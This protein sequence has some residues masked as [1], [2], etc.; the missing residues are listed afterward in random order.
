MGGLEELA[1]FSLTRP[2]TLRQPSVCVKTDCRRC[3]ANV[4]LA[5]FTGYQYGGRPLGLTYVKYMNAGSG[6]AMEDAE[7]TGITQDQIM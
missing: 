4:G 3:S 6:E 1:S 7:A 2:K 5:K